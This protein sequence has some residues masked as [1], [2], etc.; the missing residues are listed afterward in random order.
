VNRFTIL[1]GR[2]FVGSRLNTYLRAKGYAVDS[3]LR[4]EPS[5]FEQPLGHVM[6]CIGLT[7]DFRSRPFDTVEA[8]VEVLRHVLKRA[9]FETLTY[10]SSTRVYGDSARTDED[11]PLTVRP[12]NPNDLYNLSKLT[13]EALCH[14]SG[15]QGVRVARLSN[16]VGPHM[17][18]QSGNFVASLLREAACGHIVLRSH[19]ESAKDYIHIDDVVMWLP[20]LAL[21]GRSQVYNLASGTQIAHRV[22]ASWIAQLA[23]CEWS[24]QSDASIQFSAAIDA[25]RLRA[26]FGFSARAVNQYDVSLSSG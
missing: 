26:E 9:D 15:R 17:D 6:Y 2:G 21:E 14:A 11:V 1:G 4:Q 19:P 3:P 10:L 5:L 7:G 22:W 20:T 23:G 12:S 13:G 24:V 25:N 8:H 16:V 18:P